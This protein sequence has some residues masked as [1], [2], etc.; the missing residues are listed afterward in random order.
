MPDIIY[1]G[2][3]EAWALALIVAVLIEWL[4]FMFS[5]ASE[6]DARADSSPAETTSK[7]Q[8]DAEQGR[9]VFNGKGICNYCHGS[10]GHLKQ[11]PQLA[12]E[13]NAIIDRLDP[14]PANLRSPGSL[15]LKTDDERFRLIREGHLGTGMFPDTTLTDEEITDTLAYLTALREASAQSKSDR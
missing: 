11:R 14:K 8:G 5:F 12:P 3:R 15:K 7:K 9:K 6:N 4:V 2:G 13:T 10:D 1:R